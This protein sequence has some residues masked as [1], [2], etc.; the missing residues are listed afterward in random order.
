MYPTEKELICHQKKG[1]IEPSKLTDVILFIETVARIFEFHLKSDG[2]TVGKANGYS[3]F[4]TDIGC[5]LVGCVDENGK[6]FADQIVQGK[7][8]IIA[9]PKGRHV[10]GRVLSASLH[11]DGWS[12]EIWK[13]ME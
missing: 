6:L 12:Y 3:P 13:D 7:H 8:L 2:R 11:G 5:T 9:T 4:M 1:I 10:T